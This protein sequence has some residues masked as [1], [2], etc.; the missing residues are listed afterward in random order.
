MIWAGF[1]AGAGGTKAFADAI[2]LADPA[3]DV[4]PG[5]VVMVVLL[6]RLSPAGL[7]PLA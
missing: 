6:T 7:V 2:G 3:G 4:I 1:T 5:I